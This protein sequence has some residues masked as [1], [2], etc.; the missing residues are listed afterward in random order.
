MANVKPTPEYPLA[1][2]HYRPYRYWLVILI[3]TVITALAA[4]GCYYAGFHRAASVQQVAVEELKQL[5]GYQAEKIERIQELEQQV[6]NFSLGSQVDRKATEQVRAQVV[7]LKNRIAELERD[8]T[9]YRDLMRPDNEG[10][11]ISVG[12]PTITPLSQ[13]NA[14]Q[15]KMVV[16]QLDTNRLQVGGYLEFVLVGKNGDVQKRIPLKEVS[17]TISSD[18]IKLN[19]RYFQRIEGKLVLP[20]EFT[21]DRIELKIVS[22]RPKKALIEKQFN[23]TIK[24]S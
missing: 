1:V 9:F 5:R 14:Y 20:Q 3:A 2:V 11:G 6:A 24:E 7:E 15:Y 22:V 19:F 16:K 18:R 4:F 13:A 10:Q 12:V 17:D 21:P 23:W 8:N